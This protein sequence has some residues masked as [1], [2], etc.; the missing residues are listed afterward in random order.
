VALRD[1]LSALTQRAVAA[2]AGI[3]PALVTHYW[4]SMEQL[5]ATTFGEIVAEEILDVMSLAS[6]EQSVTNSLRAIIS[7]VLDGSRD[8]VTVVWVDAWSLGRR[9][10]ILAAMIREQMNAW[11]KSLTEVI[12]EGIT[13]GEFTSPE[14]DVYSIARQIFGM[15]DGLN[16]HAL[17]DFS[18]D[19]QR[20][21]LISRALELELGLPA[22]KLNN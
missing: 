3:A 7:A 14:I 10:P 17:V 5:I 6:Q 2:E 1:G 15:V 21:H 12:D 4:P 22:G 19:G 13:S 9:M 8:D 11:H 20:L 16:A 18:E